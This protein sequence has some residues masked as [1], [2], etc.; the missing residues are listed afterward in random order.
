M[1]KK[2]QFWLMLAEVLTLSPWQS[3]RARGTTAII[4]VPEVYSHPQLG[5]D[6]P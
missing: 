5:Q 3:Q 2:N 4:L 1:F 6:H